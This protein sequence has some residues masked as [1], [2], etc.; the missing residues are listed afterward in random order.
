[1]D[2]SRA[3]SEINSNF[4]V[5]NR[6]FSDPGYLAPPAEGLPSEFCNGG[7]AQKT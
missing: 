1:M 7:E 3:V 4:S 2:T 5:K 6:K